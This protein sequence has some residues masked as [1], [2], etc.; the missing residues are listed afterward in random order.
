MVCTFEFLVCFDE[1]Y[2]TIH[3]GDKL[4]AETETEFRV[5]IITLNRVNSESIRKSRS[6]YMDW[7]KK[8]KRKPPSEARKVPGML[9][10]ILQHDNYIKQD[11][12]KLTG[13]VLFLCWICSDSLLKDDLYFVLEENVSNDSKYVM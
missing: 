5:S 1:T 9:I 7:C 12:N 10:H 8:N 6:A 11:E 3:T 4:E 13:Q 2:S